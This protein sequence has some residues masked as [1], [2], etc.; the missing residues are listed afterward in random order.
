MT[1][2]TSALVL[3]VLLGIAGVR[4]GCAWSCQPSSVTAAAGHCHETSDAAFQFSASAACNDARSGSPLLVAAS[5]S[6]G[7]TLATEDRV[8]SFS[9]AVDNGVRRRPAPARQSHATSP[10][11]FAIPL[12][13]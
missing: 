4:L 3:G 7:A 12:R 10:P 6:D 8:T 1:R 11:A 13:Q 9:L 2:V 5:R